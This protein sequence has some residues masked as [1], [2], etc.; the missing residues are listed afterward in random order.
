M[1]TKP[2]L[3]L[4]S[5]SFS[6]PLYTSSSTATAFRMYELSELLSPCQVATHNLIVAS[7]I[8]Q[9]YFSYIR[10]NDDIAHIEWGYLLWQIHRL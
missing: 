1:G 7:R 9:P 6:S 10:T 8:L 3:S 2:N 4:N 5:S